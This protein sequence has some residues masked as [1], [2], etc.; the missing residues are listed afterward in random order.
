ME[1]RSLNLV[2][3]LVIII[4]SKWTLSQKLFYEK[5]VS[6]RH[7]SFYS[8]VIDHNALMIPR[9]SRLLWNAFPSVLIR[10]CWIN[11]LCWRLSLLFLV[12]LQH[13]LH[14]FSSFSLWFFSFDQWLFCTNFSPPWELSVCIY[15]ETS[16]R[17]FSFSL[18][19]Q[20]YF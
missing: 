13:I 20:V 2:G 17:A 15:R 18:V 12:V 10:S 16:C 1:L 19:R 4:T 11:G 5:D 9:F 6:V 3:R 7:P 14:A 8:F